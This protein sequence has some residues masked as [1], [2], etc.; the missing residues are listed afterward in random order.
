MLYDG[1]SAA[2]IPHFGAAVLT[3]S[4]FG[5]ESRKSLTLRH[6]N[7]KSSSFLFFAR[8]QYLHRKTD[9]DP[10]TQVTYKLKN[11]ESVTRGP[12]LALKDVT[13]LRTGAAGRNAVQASDTNVY[14][15]PVVCQHEG[16]AGAAG[17]HER[18]P[19]RAAADHV[20]WL[21][22]RTHA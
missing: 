8:R 21:M 9:H 10:G 1:S 22:E 12:N 7:D 15:P 20:L 11:L 5:S 2:S 4:R 16:A 13:R 17:D 14:L 3:S 19:L 18:A 6:K